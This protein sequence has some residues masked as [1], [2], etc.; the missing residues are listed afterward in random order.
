MFIYVMLQNGENSLETDMNYEQYGHCYID[1]N[2]TAGSAGV[3]RKLPGW[4]SKKIR[5][6]GA[7]L[8]S[9]SLIP[10]VHL[11]LR[12]SP[13]IF[14]NIRNDPIVLFSGA[15]GKVIMKKSEEKNLATR[16]I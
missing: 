9:V 4:G 12:I 2:L 16:S 14:E 6:P 7:N 13:R 5:S 11:D 10:V 8:P 1:K 15:W 3:N